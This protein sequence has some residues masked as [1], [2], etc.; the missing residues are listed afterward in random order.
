MRKSNML[1]V[2]LLMY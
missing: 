2:E 1:I